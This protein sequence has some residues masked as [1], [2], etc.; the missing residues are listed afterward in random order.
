MIDEGKKAKARTLQIATKGSIT[1]GV[2]PTKQ[3]AP[4]VVKPTVK[5]ESKAITQRIHK[6]TGNIQAGLKAGFLK[7]KGLI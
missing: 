1:K 3:T 7:E 4:N 5:S 6:Q 2:T